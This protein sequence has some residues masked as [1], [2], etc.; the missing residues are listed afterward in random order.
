MIVTLNGS[1]EELPDGAQLSDLLAVHGHT[2]AARGIAIA[3]NGAVV[4]RADWAAQALD[5]G[6]AVELLVAVQGG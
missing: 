2:T 6:D 1:P 4:R 3:L 5:D